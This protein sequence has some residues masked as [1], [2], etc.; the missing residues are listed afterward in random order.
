MLSFED[1]VNQTIK[2]II[3]NVF[4]DEK[5]VESIFQ[6]FQKASSNVMDEN[7]QILT[8]VLPKILGSGAVIVEDLILETLYSKYNLD[9]VWKKDYRFADYLNELR[10]QT[11]GELGSHE[12]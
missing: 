11:T 9:I 5:V 6:Y 4:E 7:A 12:A 10:K 8:D 1:T 2:Q 3:R